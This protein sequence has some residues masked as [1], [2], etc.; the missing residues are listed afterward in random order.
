M[1]ETDHEQYLGGFTSANLHLK[2]RGVSSMGYGI[3]ATSRRLIGIN[4]K[5][6]LLQAVGGFVGGATGAAMVIAGR[7]EY[8]AKTIAELQE[9]KDFEIWKEQISAIQISRPHFPRVGGLN[10]VLVTGESVTITIA[11]KREYE[12]VRGLMAVFFPERLQ[13]ER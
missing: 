9:K 2:G 5:K 8:S 11:D 6:G 12:S 1:A 13:A 7:D 4:S 3:Y 10:I